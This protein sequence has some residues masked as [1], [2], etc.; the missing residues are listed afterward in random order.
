MKK[1]P[2]QTARTRQNLIDAFWSLYAKN[3]IQTIS[4]KAI[5]AKAGYNRGTFYEYFT[6][7]YSVL[8]HIEQSILPRS[9]DELPPRTLVTETGAEQPLD[10][11][12]RMFEQNR[13]YYV[14]LLG[15]R[16]DPAFP[17]RIKRRVRPILERML[18]GSGDEF[19]I[20]ITIEFVLSAMIGVLSYWFSRQDKPPSAKLLAHMYDLMRNGAL[21][22]WMA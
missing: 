19:E 18:S 6:D 15:E 8:E 21:H 17:G 10:A 9:P 13:K 7:V 12:I 3:P 16:G 11:F 4:V 5:A 14:V 1:Q 22:R 20:D 2:E